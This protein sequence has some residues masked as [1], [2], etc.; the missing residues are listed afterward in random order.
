MVNLEEL[1]N[2]PFGSVIDVDSLD[3]VSDELKDI[4]K[5]NG[6]SSHTVI[7]ACLRE[8]DGGVNLYGRLV[9]VMLDAFGIPKD[10]ESPRKEKKKSKEKPKEEFDNLAAAEPQ[11][12]NKEAE[13]AIPKATEATSSSK[14][15]EALASEADL[16]EA[17]GGVS[18]KSKSEEVSVESKGKI[19]ETTNDSSDLE[20]NEPKAKLADDAG[21]E[22]LGVVE[23]DEHGIGDIMTEAKTEE[24]GE[25]VK[26]ESYWNEGDDRSPFM[27]KFHEFMKEPRHPEEISEFIKKNHGDID[28]KRILKVIKFYAA[29]KMAKRGYAL[30]HRPDGKVELAVGKSK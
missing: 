1:A 16:S 13:G 22:K 8:K 6:L 4:L 21:A 11:T 23:K 9:N 7:N 2:K 29:G 14:L 28:P 5:R 3:W 26:V 10:V 15:S 20:S 25:A 17:S 30:I 19:P 12:P 27:L 24:L 18:D